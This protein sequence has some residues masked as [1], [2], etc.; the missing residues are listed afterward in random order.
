MRINHNQRKITRRPSSKGIVWSISRGGVIYKRFYQ[1]VSA[2][3]DP[4]LR[5][6]VN[7]I[8]RRFNNF[9]LTLA[10]FHHKM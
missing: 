10:V 2:G 3:F 1:R 4:G 9:V 6:S 5:E 8:N 7:L